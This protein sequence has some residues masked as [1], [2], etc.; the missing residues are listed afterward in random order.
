MVESCACVALSAP[1]YLGMQEKG[2]PIDGIELAEAL[3]R[4]K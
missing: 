2:I 4:G 3:F 1:G